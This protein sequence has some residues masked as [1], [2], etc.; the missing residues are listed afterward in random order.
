MII[1]LWKDSRNDYGILKTLKNET[2]HLVLNKGR[3]TL[4]IPNKDDKE[5]PLRKGPEIIK[6][7]WIRNRYESA[8]EIPPR[9]KWK[10]R[11]R[12]RERRT[13]ETGYLGS[14]INWG[15]RRDL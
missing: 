8:S 9:H 5:D 11:E 14:G 10:S 6:E 4:E 13:H 7:T 12:R 2:E 1:S 3:D 15:S